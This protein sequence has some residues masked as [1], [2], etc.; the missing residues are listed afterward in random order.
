[1]FVYFV[2]ILL[3][4][5]LRDRVLQFPKGNSKNLIERRYLKYICIILIILAAL[6]AQSVGTDTVYY[7]SDYDNISNLS[8]R[9]IIYGDYRE[10]PGFYVLAKICSILKFPIQLLFG[11]VELL[12][13]YSIAKFIDRYSEDKLYSVLC[14]SMIGLFSFSLAGLKQTLSMSFVLLYFLSL[15]D[16]KY[17]KTVLFALGAYFCHHSSLIFL[18]GCVLYI[19]RK[20]KMFYW[21]LIVIVFVV[22]LGTSFLWEKSLIFLGSESYSEKYLSYENDSYS[23]TTM[24]FYGLLLL[25]LFIFSRSYR[26]RKKE[27]SRIMLGMATLAFA[28]QAFSFQSSAAFRLSYFFLPFMIVGFPNDFNCVDN[29]ETKRI[30]K[31]SVA[32]M[33]IFFFVYGNRNGGSVVP[34][35]FFWQDAFPL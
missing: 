6:R 23:A 1:M 25:T 32:F 20:T 4:V 14:F 5:I 26:I 15:A 33:V 8:F 3:I 27:E 19:L 12:Y 17:L 35:R 28:L 22:F 16:K 13:V 21:Y 11:L 9:N 34:Y 29:T 10:F 2:I 24:V 7:W 31:F 30:L 18:L